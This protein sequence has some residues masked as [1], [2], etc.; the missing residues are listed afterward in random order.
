MKKI[1]I[2]LA[3]FILAVISTSS[4]QTVQPQTNP[5][6]QQ[7]PLNQPAAITQSPLETQWFGVST[8]F[9]LGLNLHYGLNDIIVQD[10][11][12]RINGN[13]FAGSLNPLQMV[14]GIGVDG[15]YN[16]ENPD[17]PNLGIYLGGGLG[18]VLFLGSVNGNFGLDVHG[19]AGAEY[20]FAEYGVFG[21]VNVGTGFAS[22]YGLSAALRLGFNYHFQ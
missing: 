6:S 12:L 18:T 7:Q 5:Q 20:R 11:D 2:L 17:S 4:A 9:P 8:G 22:S 10:L 13:L 15:L 19:L 16:L 3:I 21:E 14:L 1:L